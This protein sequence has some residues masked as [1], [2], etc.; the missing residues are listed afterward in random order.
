M[1]LTAPEMGKTSQGSETFLYL[2]SGRED[3]IE[4]E[5]GSSQQ[6]RGEE[7]RGGRYLGQPGSRSPMALLL[8]E[9]KKWGIQIEPTLFGFTLQWLV[10]FGRD[11]SCW[12]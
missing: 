9:G 12:E 4:R 11:S 6:Q 7:R 5:R 10:S 1:S 8:G 3:V 2:S